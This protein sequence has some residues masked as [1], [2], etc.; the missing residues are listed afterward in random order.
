MT[1]Q[2]GATGRGLHRRVVAIASKSLLFMHASPRSA[3]MLSRLRSAPLVGGLLRAAV[4]YNRVY[5]DL[6]SAA[7]AIAAYQS[8]GGHTAPEAAELHMSFADKARASDYP[9]LF[10]LK[11]AA[12]EIR[13]VF[14]FGGCVGNLFYCYDGYLRFA[15][16]LEWRLYDLPD[17]LERARAIAAQR[18]ESRIRTVA[19]LEDA[20]GADLFLASGSMHYFDTPLADMIAGLAPKPRYVLINRTPMTSAPS[21]ATVQA[22]YGEPVA[23]MIYNRASTIESFERIGYRCV[24][25]WDVHDLVMA[26]PLHADKPIQ[27][28]GMLF[29]LA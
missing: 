19:N 7:D 14:D 20:S 16:D 2:L 9:V 13:S 24:D 4:G 17:N 21:F 22:G 5:P 12:G 18:G 25:Q 8:K 15:P 23:A 27:Y 6:K 11:G 26:V 3:R 29:R 28:A 10:H 1:P